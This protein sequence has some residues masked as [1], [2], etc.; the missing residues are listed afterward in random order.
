MNDRSEQKT[1]L[2]LGKPV[3]YSVRRSRR[4]RRLHLHVSHRVGL[5]VVLPQRWPLRDV[6]KAIDDHAKWIDKLQ[7]AVA[8]AE[9]T[10]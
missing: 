8:K 3:R 6:D 9:K 2:I 4:A 7:K 10:Q 1:T 5:E